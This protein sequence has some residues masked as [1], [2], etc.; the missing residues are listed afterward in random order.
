[1]GCLNVHTSSWIEKACCVFDDEI[2]KTKNIVRF[3]MSV[4]IL[5]PEWKKPFMSSACMAYIHTHSYAKHTIP[6][7]NYFWLIKCIIWYLFQ[8]TVFK[9][10]E[11]LYYINYC[12]ACPIYLY[13]RRRSHYSKYMLRI[14]KL[15][16]PNFWSTNNTNI[17]WYL[18][19]LTTFLCGLLHLNLKV[20]GKE[21]FWY[22]TDSE[23]PCDPLALINKH[24]SFKLCGLLS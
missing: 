11:T 17:M 20:L 23:W 1:M 18:F 7:Q 4:S 3:C 16:K 22:C 15:L 19:W 21:E 8:T 13:S 2:N 10:Y 6:H 24:I 5:F 14:W 9:Q 12:F